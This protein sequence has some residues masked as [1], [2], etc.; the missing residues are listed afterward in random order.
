M[1]AGLGFLVPLGPEPWMVHGR[2]GVPPPSAK[3]LQGW[4][5]RGE[6]PP[7]LAPVLL[8]QPLTGSHKAARPQGRPASPGPVGFICL[9][10]RILYQLLGRGP[11]SQRSRYPVPADIAVIS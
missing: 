8:P 3:R 10:C 9:T 7:G 2:L 5:P 1:P 11:C 6:P 4:T